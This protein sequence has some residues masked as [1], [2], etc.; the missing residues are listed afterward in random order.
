M[1]KA[2]LK[3]TPCLLNKKVTLL[4]KPSENWVWRSGCRVQKL[5]TGE[6]LET[7]RI[8]I[9]F[10]E[11]SPKKKD[12]RSGLVEKLE[13]HGGGVNKQGPTGPPVPV[14]EV[15]LEVAMHIHLYVVVAVFSMMGQLSRAI[16]TIWSSEPKVFTDAE[17]QEKFLFLLSGWG[18]H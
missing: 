12:K 3:G 14:N 4:R 13:E 11:G 2:R 17:L 1:A 9:F 5:E 8:T 18:R 7:M 10:Q 15:V 6:N 16:G